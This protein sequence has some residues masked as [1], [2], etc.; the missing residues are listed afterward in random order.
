MFGHVNMDFC[1]KI[2]DKMSVKL[3]I[4]KEFSFLCNMKQF[5]LSLPVNFY[6]FIIVSVLS[7]ETVSTLFLACLMNSAS[8]YISKST[9]NMCICGHFDTFYVHLN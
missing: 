6:C 5:Y 1:C 3:Q 9:P 7:I 4:T 2:K 8:S